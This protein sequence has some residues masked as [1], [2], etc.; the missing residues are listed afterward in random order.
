MV[1]INCSGTTDHR[2]CD[3]NPDTAYNVNAIGTRNL[4]VQAH[5][6][7]AKFVQISTDDVFDSFSGDHIIFNEFDTPVPKTVYGR[8][9]YAGEHLIQTLIHK[10]FIIRSSWVYGTENDYVNSVCHALEKGEKV[11]ASQKELAV[12]TYSADIA[13]FIAKLIHTTFYGIYHIT[14]KGS[15]SRY[16]YACE[17]AKI[18]G[19]NTDL[20][21]PSQT[22]DK[23][24][25]LDNMMLRLNGL[26]ELDDWKMTLRNYLNS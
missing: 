13:D 26:N 16:E 6:F 2:L 19:Y 7:N 20:I 24:T 15:C 5:N 4:A 9:K 12:P 22:P 17:I 18:K 11:Y 21:I 8:S 10:Y 1:I 14:G 23:S 25:I 3:K